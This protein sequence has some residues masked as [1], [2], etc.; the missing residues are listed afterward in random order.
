VFYESL[1]V[2]FDLRLVITLLVSSS[3]AIFN[4]LIQIYVIIN[5]IYPHVSGS[6]TYYIQYFS[7]TVR[8]IVF[9]YVHIKKSGK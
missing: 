9:I 4:I 8:P 6:R 2:L 7:N 3:F 5:F 1:F